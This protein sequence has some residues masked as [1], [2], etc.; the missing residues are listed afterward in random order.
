M[1]LKTLSLGLVLSVLTASTVLANDGKTKNALPAGSFKGDSNLI[2]NGLT[3]NDVM[4]LLIK[5]DPENKDRSYAILAEYDRVFGTNITR[6][7]ALTKWVNRMYGYRIDK[8]SDLKYALRPLKVTGGVI[9][10]DQTVQ[11]DLLTLKKAGTLDGAILMRINRK[12]GGLEETVTFQGR[13]GSTWEK[14]TSGDYYGTTERSGSAYFSSDINTNV[15]AQGIVTFDQEHIKGEYQLKESVPGMFNFIPTVQSVQL[16]SDKVIDRIAV[17]IDIVNW[18]P[19]ATTEELLL[20]NPN[21]AGDVG[22][23]YERH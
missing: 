21:D 19:L 20:I 14:L 16:G 23:Y 22:F 18:K 4:A 1:S 7:T 8:I 9:I 10:G 2:D 6:K 15:S 3:G 5:R 11:P 17:F 13:V 12:T